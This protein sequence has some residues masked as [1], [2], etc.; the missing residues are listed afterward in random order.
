MLAL[1]LT[2]VVVV[3]LSTCNVSGSE[4]VLL[5]ESMTL[6]LRLKNPTEHVVPERVGELAGCCEIPVGGVPR[7]LAVTRDE[8][9]LY[10]AL[11]DL[12]GFVI[13]DIGR[14]QVVR[15]INLP[16]LPKDVK[17]PVPYTPTM[18]WGLILHPRP[19]CSSPPAEL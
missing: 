11:S 5:T 16:P 6:P 13:A 19:S 9:T 15:T 7:P 4:P 1:E 17:F 12:H 2:P 3:P 8:K 18:K 14:R 10:C